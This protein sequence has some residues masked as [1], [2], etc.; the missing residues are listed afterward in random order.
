MFAKFEPC[1]QEELS[2]VQAF[3][4]EHRHGFANQCARSQ[5]SERFTAPETQG[6]GQQ[7]GAVHWVGGRRQSATCARK[8]A[9]SSCSGAA[10]IM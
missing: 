3:L 10:P 1:P 4:G 5:P 7:A 6:I 8:R 9:R 2:R